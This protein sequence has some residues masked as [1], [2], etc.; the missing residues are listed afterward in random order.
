MGIKVVAIVPAAGIGQRFSGSVRKS[1]ASVAGMPVLIHTLKRLQQAGPVTEIIPVVRTED[2][3][4]VSEMVR[5]YEL[6]KIRRVV[7]GGR[8]RQDS[9]YNA[10][11]QIKEESVVMVHDGVRPVIST[12][13]IEKLIKELDGFDGVVPAV[14]VKDTLKKA[15]DDGTVLSTEARDKLWSVQTPQ[16][17]PLNVIK[18]AY[19]SA[20]AEGFY[21]TDDSALVE[22]TGGRVRIIEGSPFNIKITTPEDLDMV[23][24][25]LAFTRKPRHLQRG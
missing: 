7:P 19:D 15:G 5:E 20:F 24:F 6:D 10:L 13:L 23:E 22:R 8:E 18:K 16:V 4:R 1:L 12:E 17:F 11:K 9:V 14:P 3:D 21:A 2:T 25:L